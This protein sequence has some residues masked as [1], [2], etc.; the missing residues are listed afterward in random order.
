MEK[1]LLGII[2]IK[3]TITITNKTLV[4]KSKKVNP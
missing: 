3:N 1:S 2:K 4:R